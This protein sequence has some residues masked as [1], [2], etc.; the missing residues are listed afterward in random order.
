LR[1]P[2]RNMTAGGLFI[3]KPNRLFPGSQVGCEPC[4]RITRYSIR[5]L[6][7]LEEDAGGYWVHLVR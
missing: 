2:V 4:Q 3:F 1:D 5:S 7:A 6:Q